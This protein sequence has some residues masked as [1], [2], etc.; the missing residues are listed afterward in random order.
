MALERYNREGLSLSNVHGLSTQ[1]EASDPHD[2]IYAFV[3]L[4]KKAQSP[5]ADYRSSICQ[6]YS[7]ISSKLFPKMGSLAP[8][9]F[10]TGK[11]D[12]NPFELPSW[13]IDWSRR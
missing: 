3:D 1:R 7:V 9:R 8:L 13:V 12:K 2:H 5:P 10:A 11:E 4:T 6:L